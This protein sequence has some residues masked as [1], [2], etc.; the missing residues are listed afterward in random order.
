MGKDHRRRPNRAD[1][2]QTTSRQCGDEAS[3]VLVSAS[4]ISRICSLSI[5]A[6]GST[7]DDAYYIGGGISYC[8]SNCLFLFL[9]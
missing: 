5:A 8:V 3:T 9:D 6:T 4:D 7:T 2:L 1:S